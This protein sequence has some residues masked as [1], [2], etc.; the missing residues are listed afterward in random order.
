MA[1]GVNIIPIKPD[2]HSPQ[3]YDL[4]RPKFLDEQILSMKDHMSPEAYKNALVF[5]RE[6]DMAITEPTRPEY[7]L[8]A[9]RPAVQTEPPLGQWWP[10]SPSDYSPW[11]DFSPYDS[12]FPTEMFPTSFM[13]SPTD[14]YTY[15]K[16]PFSYDFN[17][18]FP[19]D[20]APLSPWENNEF[21]AQ[22]YPNDMLSDLDSNSTLD[23]DSLEGH[24]DGVESDTSAEL[25]LDFDMSEDDVSPTLLDP[26]ALETLM[27]EL[28]AI[29][30]LIDQPADANPALDAEP[31]AADSTASTE[32]A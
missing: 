11:D 4:N 26:E 9:R 32:S 2:A 7:N 22:V 5:L 12:A 27:Q 21:V 13:T 3:P 1:F 16:Y 15:D 10:E 31:N 6:R 30:N 29:V 19:I 8:P 20:S 14:M 25:D 24:Q 23:L 28:N 18:E 17:T